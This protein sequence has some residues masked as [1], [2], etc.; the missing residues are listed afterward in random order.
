MITG[1]RILSGMNTWAQRIRDLQS[2]GMTLQQIADQV[3]LA[4]SSIGDIANERSEAPRG[5]AAVALYEL[6]RRVAR[7]QRKAAA[8]P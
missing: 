7:R 3:G 2:Y 5:D 6:H 1:S 4:T 8:T